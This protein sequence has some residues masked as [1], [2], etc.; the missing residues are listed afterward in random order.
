MELCLHSLVCLYAVH[1]D[2]FTL[3]NIK[4][5]HMQHQKFFI[6]NALNRQL[7]YLNF[8]S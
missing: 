2:K 1:G 6:T 5:P 8:R 4:N 7:I 3:Y